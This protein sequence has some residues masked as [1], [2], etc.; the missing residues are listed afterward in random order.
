MDTISDFLT[1]NVNNIIPGKS[2][3]EN[4]LRG[5]RKIKAYLGID[6]TSTNIHLG[7]AVPLR[8]LQSL[9]DLGHQV[10]F[11]IGDFTTLVGDNSDKESERPILTEEQIASNFATYQ[12]QASKF[13]D[14]SRVEVVHNSSW[15]K[16][17]TFGQ[18]VKLCQA[19][20]LNDYIGREIM[21]KKL[22]SGT[23][24]RLDELLYPIMQ[25]YDSY[26][27][28]AD[29]QIGGPDQT[30]NMQ[31]GRTLQKKLRNK[32]AFVMSVDY[33]PGTDG[34]KMSKSWGNAVWLTDS[35]NDV[36]GKVMSIND[37]LII[38]YFK[39]GTNLTIEKITDYDLALKS[40]ENPM[41]IKKDLALQITSE[42]H[43]R[44]DAFSAKTYFEATIQNK[45]TPADIPDYVLTGKDD[46]KVLTIL[47]ERKLASSSSEARRL[48]TQGG[49][50]LDGQTI[51]DYKSEVHP[52]VLS[53]GSRKF[54]RLIA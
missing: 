20:T 31:A 2:E 49:V 41:D 18:V 40:G 13:L 6:P 34:R 39:F 44:Q 48:I 53:V 23:S 22:N 7:H 24:I 42:L 51:S 54:L 37:D 32:D 10:V 36:F 3:L 38:P 9:L 30:F 52:G 21:K 5:S 17:L 46:L 33:L 15:L 1:R 25:G 19:F 43:S 26:Y 28:D 4:A 35:P 47:V 8:K 50:K 45:E 29:L 11:L 14:F 27:L 16:N 12:A